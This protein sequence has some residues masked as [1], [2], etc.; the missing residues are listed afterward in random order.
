MESPLKSFRRSS[1]L[2]QKE[3]ASLLGYSEQLVSIWERGAS[4]PD[5][6]A[7]SNI[8][9]IYHISLSTLLLGTAPAGGPQV[10]MDFDG[11]SF[12]L[13][14]LQLRKARGLAQTEVAEALGINAKTIISF[15]KGKSLPSHK[16]F[17]S[18]CDFYSV[19]PEELYYGIKIEKDSIVEEQPPNL[20]PKIPF[21]L[22]IAIYSL[23]PVFLLTLF[24]PLL[25]P[26][27]SS[28]ISGVNEPITLNPN[29]GGETI[30]SLGEESTPGELPNENH[31]TNITQ[32]SAS[33]P[34]GDEVHAHLIGKDGNYLESIPLPYGEEPHFE[35]CLDNVLD[36]ASHIAYVFQGFEEVDGPCYTDFELHA[37]YKEVPLD[38]YRSC[39]YEFCFTSDG[40]GLML[41]R[42]LG[43]T[44]ERYEIPSSLL[45]YPVRELNFT[46]PEDIAVK[47][48][49]IPDTV[50]R[51][52]CP[53]IVNSQTL[54]SVQLSERLEV[55]DNY[56]APSCPNLNYTNVE[57]IIYLGSKTNPFLYCACTESFDGT[58]TFSSRCRIVN[59]M[60][61][62]EPLEKVILPK[63]VS[64][65]SRSFL[66]AFL[67]SPAFEV[68][69]GNPYLHMEE[70]CLI[71]NRD[72]SLIAVNQG[73]SSLPQGIRRIQE[74]AL[75]NFVGE[76]L[77]LP[78]SLEVIE[79]SLSEVKSNVQH[80]D[81][82]ASFRSLHHEAFR[83]FPNIIG[84]EVDP[85]NEAFESYEDALYSK[86]KQR[87][88]VYPSKCER[89][90]FVSLED[91]KS[92]GRFCF[93]QTANLKQVR[94]F[95]ATLEQ[96]SVLGE[97]CFSS[98]LELELAEINVSQIGNSAFYDCPKLKKVV[99]GKGLIHMEAA[100]FEGCLGLESVYYRGNE[101]EWKA[102]C[103]EGDPFYP[104][105]PKI[106]FLG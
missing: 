68:E 84:I 59:L 26:V 56:I 43:E 86:G 21:S 65:L 3:V 94:I 100:A 5:A 57:N 77:S 40:E 67:R 47:E 72:A 66:Q 103:S 76:R 37:K 71:D 22:Q 24:L 29:I 78:S 52:R 93:S 106:F 20:R 18:L 60:Q 69:A 15:E 83:N 63:S 28:G 74:H 41:N 88:F 46:L 38:D 45:G 101:N 6:S 104:N 10:D 32:L 92:V 96:A 31:P 73:V 9:K 30:S 4:F 54:I 16:T 82:G 8:C 55:V 62:F 98:C 53:I 42:F 25:L 51:I 49:L 19:S 23:L 97:H 27:S 91:T 79:G 14:L 87:L 95:P 102:I 17:L 89:E 12:S 75:N 13:R 33:L 80:V 35:F 58:I 11:P 70:G 99:L 39:L 61:S 90:I 48:L 2:T 44:A 36:E 81:V 105:T 34:F 7:W 64:Y 50:T 1:G 85:E